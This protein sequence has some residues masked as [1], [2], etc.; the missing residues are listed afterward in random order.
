MNSF[1]FFLSGKPFICPLILND[2]FA[3]QSNLGCRSLLFMTWN[4]SCLSLLA[5]KIS[6]EKSADSL[7]GT[8]LQVTNFFS[9]ATFK[10]PCSSL[11]FYILIMMCL[12]GGLFASFLFGIFSASWTCV[13]I[14][15]TKLGKLSF[16]IFSNRFPIPC[17]FS[18]SGTP[19]M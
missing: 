13:S 15:F 1:S 14:S 9:L 12:R 19:M 8:P 7:K 3:G 18:S 2:S 17:F 4:I 10:I 6:F 16:I 11:T 5:C